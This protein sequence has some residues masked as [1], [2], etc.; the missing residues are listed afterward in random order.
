M[1]GTAGISADYR[2]DVRRFAASVVGQLP[3]YVDS[4]DP[5]AGPTTFLDPQGQSM[6]PMT[7]AKAKST[8]SE[9]LAVYD[10]IAHIQG[11][12]G[13][14]AALTMANL[15]ESQAG[16]SAHDQNLLGLLHEGASTLDF[17]FGQ[18]NPA[19][20][21]WKVTGI[22]IVGTDT[23]DVTY[24]IA[25]P[26]GRAWHFAESAETKRLHFDRRSDGQWVLDGWLNYAAFESRV[27]RSVTPADELPNLVQ[28]WWETLGAD[29]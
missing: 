25:A 3:I 15:A 22:A 18:P 28:N 2:V 14:D 7:T 13:A 6:R 26:V 5:S 12:T 11:S 21:T 29:N 20:W 8:L 24:R 1:D 9:A 10:R 17:M 23:A 27:R 4:A 19:Q 16:L